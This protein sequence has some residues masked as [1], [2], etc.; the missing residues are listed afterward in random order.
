MFR[1]EAALQK[2]KVLRQ[3]A[4]LLVIFLRRLQVACFRQGQASKE[5]LQGRCCAERAH[6]G[7]FM[8]KKKDAELLRRVLKIACMKPCKWVSYPLEKM[9]ITSNKLV[10]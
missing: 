2:T 3:A 10:P 5:G 1:Q 8:R 6:H 9:M 7:K 4:R